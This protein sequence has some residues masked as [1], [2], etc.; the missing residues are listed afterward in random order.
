M[1]CVMSRISASG[2]MRLITP[3]HVPTKSSRSPKS[4]R[5]VMNTGAMLNARGRRNGLDQAVEIVTLGLGDHLQAVLACFTGGLGAN[6][7]RRDLKAERG[8]AAPA[9]GD[10]PVVAGPADFLRAGRLELDQ[11]AEHN[12]EPECFQ[13]LRKRPSGVAGPSHDY[14]RTPRAG[15]H[16]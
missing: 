16:P 7:D 11:R 5:K 4:D 3:W 6:R 9:P 10:D 12:F 13:P 14:A 1:P 8:R 15:T 2:A